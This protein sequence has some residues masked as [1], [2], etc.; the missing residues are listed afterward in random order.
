MSKKT[1]EQQIRLNQRINGIKPSIIVKTEQI[2]NTT[3]N[4]N[5][6]KSI[7]AMA[8]AKGQDSTEAKGIKRYIGIAS[9]RVLGICPN[10]EALDAI[11]G[12]TSENAPKYIGEVEV[13]G[14][15]V[16]QARIDILFKLDPEKYLD[17]E[18]KPIET[19]FKKSVFLT[20]T[21]QG[22]VTGKL[23]Q[24]LVILLSRLVMSLFI[25]KLLFLLVRTRML[26]I[27]VR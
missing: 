16:P 15:K 6:S 10:K 23:T 17:G 24:K 19:V 20:N 14:I 11:Y 27:L 5:K 26:T 13:N 7:V 3:K 22:I 12:H 9:C 8:I 2:M 21:L 25:P 4:N 18:G 1:F